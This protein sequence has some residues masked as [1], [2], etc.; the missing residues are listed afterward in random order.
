[1]AKTLMLFAIPR[2]IVTAIKAEWRSWHGDP[3]VDPSHL[4]GGSE[5]AK[6]GR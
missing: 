4:P 3:M 2:K 1:M 6:R 5:I